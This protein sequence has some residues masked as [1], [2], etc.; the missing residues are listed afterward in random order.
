[1]NRTS[2]LVIFSVLCV[3]L[4]FGL[5]SQ[6]R[7]V[8]VQ[9]DIARAIEKATLIRHGSS[10]KRSI[11]LIH[12]FGAAIPAAPSIGFLTAGVRDGS[13]NS[14]YAQVAGDF[15]GDGK[16]DT[17]TIVGNGDGVTFWVSIMLGQ[18]NGTFAPAVLSSVSFGTGDRLYAADLNSDSDTDL[19]LLHTGNLDVLISNGDGTF[20]SPVN[21][22]EGVDSF[23]GAYIGDLNS[24]GAIDVTVLSAG[25]A[26]PMVSTLLG[27]GNGTFGAATLV[28]FPAQVPNAIFADV[29]GDGKLD[30]ISS[31]AVFLANVTGYQSGVALMNAPNSGIC[32]GNDG[33]IAVAD[34][35]RDSQPDIVTADCE[36]NTVSVYLNA[37]NGSFQPATSFWAGFYPQAI[38]I[39]DMNGDGI[40]DIVSSNGYSSDVSILTGKGDGTFQPVKVGYSV[41]GLAYESPLVAD[42]NNDGIPD[43]LT[44]NYV[45]DLN[46]S[47]AYVRGLGNQGYIAA[48]DYFSPPPPVS[49]EFGLGIS[50]ADFNGDGRLDFVIGNSGS[51]SEGVTVFLANADSSVQPGVNFGTGGSLNFVGTGDF[52]GDCKQD[53]VAAD[54]ST[55]ELNLF[56]GNGDG[57]FQAAQTFSATSGA[58]GVAVADFN[59]DGKP[60]VAAMGSDLAILIN[61]GTGAFLP[62]TTYPSVSNSSLVTAADVNGDGKIDLVL[63]QIGGT[64]LYLLLGNGDG[65]FQSAPDIALGY[66]NPARV[67]VGDFNH[68]GKADIAVAIQDFGG[69]GIAIALGNGDGSFQPAVLYACSTHNLASELPYPSGIVA[70]DVDGDGNLDLVY[71]ETQAGLAG[72]IFGKGDGTFSAPAEFA[73][74]AYPYDIV[75]ADVNGDGAQDAVMSGGL[76]SGIT[77]LLNT[78]GSNVS[79]SSSVNPS[80]SGQAVTFTA[81]ITPAVA[82]VSAVPSGTITFLDGNTIVGT[83][84]VSAGQATLA[85]SNLAVGTHSITA[86]YSGSS[87]FVP[88]V[89]SALTQTVMAGTSSFTL[90]ASPTNP[91]VHRGSST[92]VA[93]TLTP[94][95]GYTGTVNLSCSGL[96]TGISCQFTP[97]SIRLS[98]V[99][100]VQLK[101]AATLSAASAAPVPSH[102]NG[103]PLWTT[104]VFG[105]VLLEGMGTRR[106]RMTAVL[107]ILAIVAML[108]LVGCGSGTGS[109]APTPPGS[110]GPGH[111]TSL[112]TIHVIATGPAAGGGTITQQ[113]SIKLSVKD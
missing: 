99:A 72:T 38:S 22:N 60:D 103:I 78:G 32:G 73:A 96:T 27:N 100:S 111:N 46:F 54:S 43:V 44:A 56:L 88:T 90:S 79:I 69:M 35:N 16:Q 113:V 70:T 17:A 93:L 48:R 59:G 36:Y 4:A 52:N 64:A 12:A 47:T 51:N 24:D 40:L 45:T 65:T 10:Q 63:P 77:V 98:G 97:S 92:T 39:A 50:S 26:T 21:Y 30:V 55:G 1:M 108:A 87:S 29:N 61:D 23:S 20:A 89:S 85:V 41:G 31:L 58:E 74:G 91:T 62:A 49:G 19:L 95:N 81:A 102:T 15:N 25:S 94:S 68:D 86:K 104:G 106:R 66:S 5:E 13:G 18:G 6:Q 57:T 42:L 7:K 33:A 110:T 3:N 76:F 75:S 34:L 11:P 8:G 83:A 101:L 37:G 112:H 14:S 80:A 9:A 84:T 67:T 71:T 107:A 2:A 82:G 53:I 105:F 109:P 28:S